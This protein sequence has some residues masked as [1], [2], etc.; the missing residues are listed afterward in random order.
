MRELT[1]FAIAMTIFLILIVV[2][3]VNQIRKW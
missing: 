2:D 3:V 1:I